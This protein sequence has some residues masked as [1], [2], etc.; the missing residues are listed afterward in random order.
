M[1]IDVS[2]PAAASVIYVSLSALVAV[3]IWVE[4]QMLKKN[5]GKLPKVGAF[6]LIS[7][8]E[9]GWF[10]VSIAALTI[11][12]LQGLVL[13]V[14]AAYSLYTLSSWLYGIYLLRQTGLPKTPDRLI[15]PLPYI[16]FSQSFATTFF[17]LC[18][19]VLLNVGY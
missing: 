7:W 14:P 18:L 16:A 3:L 17:A 19:F 12:D 8:I 15:I 6:Y 1:L 9:A 2:T 10:L 5:K 4:G 13:A 11:L